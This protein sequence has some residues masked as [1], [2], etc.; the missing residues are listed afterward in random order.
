MSLKGGSYVHAAL[1]LVRSVRN[2]FVNG[3]RKAVDLCHFLNV[4]RSRTVCSWA[5]R[6][7]TIAIVFA[8]IAGHT[9]A[10][11]V[12]YVYDALGRL[13]AVID[14]TTGDSA[15][16]S[17]DSV[18]NILSIQRRTSAQ[19]AIFDF[20]PSSGVVGTNVTITGAGFSETA[21][22]NI[23][24][25][26]GV[27]TTVTSATLTKIVV[28]VPTGATTGPI[29]V[30]K[31][32]VTATSTKSFVVAPQV[33]LPR[34]ASF[35]P[36]AASPG[37]EVTVSGSGFDVSP[38]ATTI[39]LNG[40]FATI[41]TITP[42][43]IVFFVP[44]RTSTGRI[45]VSTRQGVAASVGDL[46]VLLPNFPNL[47]SANIATPIRRSIGGGTQLT[48]DQKTYI[49]L[50]E[51]VRGDRLGIGAYPVLLRTAGWSYFNGSFNILSIVTPDGAPL[52]SSFSSIGAYGLS[53]P[54]PTLPTTGTYAIYV[55]PNHG[56]GTAT[57]NLSRVTTGTTS[58]GGSF[59][60]NAGDVH[61]LTFSIP[62]PGFPVDVGVI[63]N[64]DPPPPRRRPPGFTCHFV[65]LDTDV[66]SQP[67][68]KVVPGGSPT[69]LILRPDGSGIAN[70]GVGGDW[71][72]SIGFLP[73]GP[74]YKIRAW[75]SSLPDCNF[76]VSFCIP[77]Q[78]QLTVDGP[79]FSIVTVCPGQSVVL[80][81]DG[82]KGQNLGIAFS[83]ADITPEPGS[84]GFVVM[85]GT[86]FVASG[87]IDKAQ[88]GSAN[89]SNLPSTGKYFVEVR[90]SGP[91]QMIMTVDLTGDKVQPITL[92][93]STPVNLVRPGQ[94][95]R[96][97]F[98]GTAGQS[99]GIGAKA[100]AITPA[101][102]GNPALRILRP[103]GTSLATGFVTL[104]GAA[105]RVPALPVTGT[106][107]IFV[108]PAASSTTSFS[109]VASL[110]VKSTLA[111]NGAAYSLSIPNLG[112]NA[113]LTF[114]GTL[115]QKITLRGSSNTIPGCTDLLLVRPS[116]AGIRAFAGCGATYDST[117]SGPITLPETGTYL[118]KVNPGLGTGSVNL[119][120][121]S[122]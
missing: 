25:F 95:A 57:I 61:E 70:V 88:G 46:I 92:G 1:C 27:A 94:N 66:N 69:I 49:L 112:Q 34:I 90:P 26:N 45:T 23:V 28:K 13:K 9:Y 12:E 72:T 115:N 97:T 21:S 77:K 16:Y 40:K 120:V 76:S 37:A 18:G 109:L 33:P 99:I 108:D 110:D 89:I 81:I 63:G 19:L 53:S 51:G 14:T 2:L 64:I 85:G 65:L 22:Q 6:G 20:S 122:P 82:V 32:A 67:I 10:G 86:S 62:P 114:T 96:L 44:Q 78:G 116:G 59:S 42:T 98:A 75:A 111:I 71:R 30:T 56:T 106:Y 11:S 83:R 118:L 50:F 79:S 74:G 117:A 102:L 113:Q 58:S 31:G 48:L 103:D 35:V 43:S 68:T 29:R 101:T 47:T 73:A 105:T 5:F 54:L 38:G 84:A 52:G 121:T 104:A 7:V 60:L 8:L 80:G 4:L 87:S 24:E 41:K 39:E 36:R 17:Y 91:G 3:C 93:V 107:T 55:S 119:K 15:E 100:A